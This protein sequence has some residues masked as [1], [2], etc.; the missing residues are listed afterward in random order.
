M[1]EVVIIKKL[2]FL[3]NMYFA[4]R[5]LH[6]ISKGIPENSMKGFSLAI[7]KGYNIELDTHLIADGNI[8]V[9][10][11]DNLK[12]MTGINK[13]IKNCT[14]LELQNY[15]LKNTNEK[16]PLLEDVLKLV[17]GKII[18]NIEL[19]YDRKSGLLEEKISEIL[20]KYKGKFIVSSFNPFSILWFKKNK[21]EYIRGIISSDFLGEKIN[22]IKKCLLKSML[23][24]F[25]IK[26]DFI[27]YDINALPNK[28][29]E[30]YRKKG[31]TIA[32]WTID[33]YDKL[34]KAKKYGNAFIF[35][36]ILI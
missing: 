19:K 16:I 7:E 3:E 30:N 35:E 29:I 8:V 26:P 28:T 32:I 15:T 12:R 14:Y 21:S 1:L 25:F 20:D 36:D 33:T 34:N 10:H 24:N 6:N 4:H 13:N 5:G 23:L 2:N 11:D 18:L 31:I 27:S 9:F 17:N 22:C